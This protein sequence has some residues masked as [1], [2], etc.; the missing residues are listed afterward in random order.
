MNELIQLCIIS[1]E[2]DARL[3]AA[4]ERKASF[5]CYRY[6]NAH[7]TSTSMNDAIETKAVK[8]VFGD[9][10]KALGSSMRLA[11]A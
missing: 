2:Y 8:G 5:K 7:G 10:A 11:V 6:I 4:T 1:A 9:H 3:N